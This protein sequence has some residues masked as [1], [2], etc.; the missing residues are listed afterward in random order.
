M[1]YVYGIAIEYLLVLA[2]WIGAGLFALRWLL[3]ARRAA[4]GTPR[5]MAV[6]NLALSAW[7]LLATLTAVEI[8]L[9]VFYDQTDS[10]N[11]T[12][13]SK[14][15]YRRHVDPYKNTEG[16]RDLRVL[17]KD[18]PDGLRVIWF[19]GDSFTFGHGV[20]DVEDRFTDRIASDLD[21]QS[22]GKFRVHNVS[23]AGSN[24][25]QA[26][27][28]L[29][30]FWGH[31]YEPPAAAVFVLCLND[32]EAFQKQS[33]ERYRKMGSWAPP[34][35]LLRE[36]YLLNFFYFRLKQ[37]R[38]P[39]FRNY[40]G[41]LAEAYAGPDGTRLLGGINNVNHTCRSN[42]VKFGLVIFPFLHNLGPKYEFAAAHERIVAHC[43]K[44]GIPVLDLRPSLEPH[45]GEGLTVN[46]F[47]AHPN[48]RAHELAAEAI[49]AKLLPE[50]LKMQPSKP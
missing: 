48:E 33:E 23:D 43:R 37:A 50:L 15:W 11:V 29:E 24:I 49:E 9:A 18:P 42:G 26:K 32:I 34:S 20:R 28:W 45:V 3:K 8:Y 6:L 46:P 35:V 44:N 2:V 38:Q 27:N 47:D 36:S 5:K 19:L 4:H 30:V 17:E 16:F 1:G 7:M 39:D 21:R 25:N 13:G 40:F 10:F 41:D 12:L 31:G 14:T 22:P